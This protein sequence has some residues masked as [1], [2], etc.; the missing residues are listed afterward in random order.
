MQYVWRRAGVSIPRT[1]YQQ[2]GALKHVSLKKMKPGDLIFSPGHV[3]MFIGNGKMVHSP[4]SGR[5]VSIDPIHSNAQIAGR[6]TAS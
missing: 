5:T 3:G 6:V 1:S 2:R 4:R